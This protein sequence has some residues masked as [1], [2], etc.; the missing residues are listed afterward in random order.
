M[1]VFNVNKAIG[2]ASSGVEYAQKYRQELFA[3]LPFDDRYIFTDYMS[4]NISEYVHSMKLPQEKIL[5][6]YSYLTKRPLNRTSF[7]VE[8]FLQT[9]KG[10]YEITAQNN[11]FIDI[12]LI[13][14]RA[15]YKIWLLKDDKIDRVD[16]IVGNQLQSVSHYDKSLSNVEYYNEGKVVR[17]VFFNEEQKISLEQFYEDNQI[18]LTFIDGKILEGRTSFYRYFLEQLEIQKEDAIIID[19]A[20]DVA[21]SILPFFAGKARL[22][23]VVHAEHYDDN[24]TEGNDIV[25]NNHYEYVFDNKQYIEA[26]IASTER[27]KLT[28][29]EQLGKQTK[30]ATIPVGYVSEIIENENYQPFAL[31]T[32]SRLANEKNIN[33][34]IKAVAQAKKE[35]PELF[36]DIYGEGQR[37]P[38]EQL[39]SEQGAQDYIKLQG[40]HQLAGVYATYGLYLSASTSEGFGL[41]LLEATRECLPIICLD[42]DYGNREMVL[43]GKNGLLVE[44]G[45]PE[46][47]AAKLAQAIIDYYEKEMEKT[48]RNEAKHIAQKYMAQEVQNKWRDLLREDV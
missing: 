22:F 33:V 11:R 17:R 26:F 29:Q 20:L 25:W 14:K 36:F 30:I 42:V 38:L 16:T 10:T 24:L 37:M 4:T 41:T 18:V 8:D 43:H 9:I 31:M 2:F 1:R 27:Q 7:C 45:T 13:G 3:D 44:N 5:W 6:I 12:T 35:I 15:I 39:I 21:D 40:H 46:E 47:N 48:A 34:L 32:A 23:S 28:M 19:R